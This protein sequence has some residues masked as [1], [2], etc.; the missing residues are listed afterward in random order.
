[1]TVIV[2]P[3]IV[4]LATAAEVVS[5]SESTLQE[6]VRKKTFPAP[7][8]MSDRRVG[9]LMREIEEWAENRPASDLLPPPNTGAKKP[10]RNQQP[11]PQADLKAA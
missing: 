4:D 3:I 10:K 6:M 2:R 5:L 11:D 7:R 9:W 8:K 1:M